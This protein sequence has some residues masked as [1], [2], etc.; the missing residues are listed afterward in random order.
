MNSSRAFRFGAFA[1]SVLA[2]VL[3]GGGFARAASSATVYAQ[4]IGSGWHPPSVS[5]DPG[6]TVKWE[7]R[8]T[9]NPHTVQCDQHDSNAPCPWSDAPNMEQRANQ[10]ATPQSVSIRFPTAGTYAYYCS[11]HPGMTGKVIVGSGIGPAPKTSSTPRA[12]QSSRPTVRTTSSVAPSASVSARASTKAAPKTTVKGK[13]ATRPAP[14]LSGKALAETKTGSKSG[15]GA[16]I[17]VPAAL[18]IALVGGAHLARA[19]RSA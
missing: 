16:G 18:L 13:T 6:G 11:I 17:L 15:P 5:I 7:N 3:V 19:R 10:F 14:S 8:D 12:T 2:F 9:G 4:D 1:A